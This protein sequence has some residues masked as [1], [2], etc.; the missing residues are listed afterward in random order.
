MRNEKR[1]LIYLKRRE[2]YLLE[3]LL[4]LIKEGRPHEPV[5]K[6]MELEVERR[7][8]SERGKRLA[9]ASFLPGIL[10][11]FLLILLMGLFSR[12]K[13]I[14]LPSMG[15]GIAVWGKQEKI[16]LSYYFDSGYL[17]LTGYDWSR[18]GL[19]EDEMQALQNVQLY[20]SLGGRDIGKGEKVLKELLYRIKNPMVR[21]RIFLALAELRVREGK[22][23]E[24]L[25]Y[26]RK[27]LETA[28]GHPALQF[29]PL[30]YILRL[31]WEEGRFEEMGKFM[32]MALNLLN[33]D[34]YYPLFKYTAFYIL[35]REREENL[36]TLWVF[37][38]LK[39]LVENF[40]SNLK[41]ANDFAST[42][43]KCSS[44]LCY[45]AMGMVYRSL[46]FR[47]LYSGYFDKF[48]SLA[49]RTPSKYPDLILLAER[50]KNAP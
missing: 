7:R 25:I 36:R 9:R 44:P 20:F 13:A 5:L 23:T 42:F 28:S 31:L 15:G 43:K 39:A 6:E 17:E 4:R 32:P 50:L 10:V 40:P 41:L 24:A 12:K 38:R 14:A 35:W 3:K 34:F 33:Q 29:D 1:I 27:S 49:R 18:A 30:S 46:G 47:K 48:L 2:I 21:S 16:M 19:S 26:A 37:Q 22:R 11:L 8:E 45:L